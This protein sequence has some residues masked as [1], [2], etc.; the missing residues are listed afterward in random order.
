MIFKQITIDQCAAL[1]GLA[2]HEILVGVTPTAAHDYLYSSYLLHHSGDGEA[3][4]DVIVADIRAA[5][6]LGE[7]KQAADLLIVLR[8]FLSEHL[9]TLVLVASRD[10]DGLP[11]SVAAK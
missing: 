6:D 8:R 1:S 4:R 11:R 2:P 3:L 10:P 9:G 5:L 7:S